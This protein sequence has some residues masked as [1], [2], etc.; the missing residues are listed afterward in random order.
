M[1]RMR[2]KIKRA[3]A[4]CEKHILR[5]DSAVLLMRDMMPLTADKYN[6]MNDEE[7]RVVDQFLFRFSK[8]QDAIG[9]KLFKAILVLLDEPVEGVS[10]LDVLNRLEK[11]GLIDEAQV[12]RELRYDRNE[13]AHNYEDDAEDAVKIIN[14]LYDKKDVLIGFHTRIKE[15][16]ERNVH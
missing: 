16:Y 3:F 5:M 8:L 13:L 2:E 7:V 12:W 4:E 6:Q 14:N 11:L 9:K 10:F 1:E 15:Y